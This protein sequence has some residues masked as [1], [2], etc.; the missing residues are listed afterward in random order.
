M[1]Y[2][3]HKNKQTREKKESTKELLEAAISRLDNLTMQVCENIIY[4]ASMPPLKRLVALR[5]FLELG[6]NG[7]TKRFAME[8]LVLDH[9]ELW[10]NIV[11]TRN[12]PEPAKR[13]ENYY[14]ESIEEIR[15]W[16]LV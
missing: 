4:N 7:S 12:V 16:C 8:N 3:G 15:R 13:N 5:V 11:D 6:G 14:K 2:L 9:K 10:Q 1:W